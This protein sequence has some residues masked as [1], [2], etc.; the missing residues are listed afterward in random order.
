[1]PNPWGRAFVKFYYHNSPP[2]AKYIAGNE[3]LKGIIRLLLLPFVALVYLI[4]NPLMAVLGLVFLLLVLLIKKKR[5]ATN[6]H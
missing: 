4:Y 3:G 1:M 5:L 2:I 6:A